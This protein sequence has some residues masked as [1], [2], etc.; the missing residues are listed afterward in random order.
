M[1]VI[2]G[3][4]IASIVAAI[5]VI[6]SPQ[7]TIQSTQFITGKLCRIAKKKKKNG[8]LRLTTEIM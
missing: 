2:E 7:H 5:G 8:W 6:C 1:I 4:G 3:S